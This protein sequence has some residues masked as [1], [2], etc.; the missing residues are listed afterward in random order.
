MSSYVLHLPSLPIPLS[1]LSSPSSLPSPPFVYISLFSSPPKTLVYL[2]PP[3]SSF[4]FA[5]FPP[6]IFPLSCPSTLLLSS[7]TLLLFPSSPFPPSVLS[8]SPSPQAGKI[9]PNSTVGRLLMEMVSRVPKIEGPKF[10]SM[11]NATMQ[12]SVMSY[13]W[14]VCLV[15]MA[16][17]TDM[18]G[19]VA[20]LC[21]N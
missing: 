13:M 1:V 11:L 2:P 5:T 19:S 12:V 3:H 15:A 17:V 16:I 21:R 9:P 14:H 18:Y 10:D 8:S 6:L 7:S 4:L 20:V